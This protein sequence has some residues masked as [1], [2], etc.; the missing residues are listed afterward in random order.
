MT[1]PVLETD[2]GDLITESPAICHYLAATSQP[3]LNGASAIHA[4]QVNQWV[5]FLR[6]KTLP[7][8]KT[9][10]GAV[11]GTIDITP[12]EHAFITNELKE[13]LKTLNNALKSK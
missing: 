10:A 12:E 13:N 3:A 4:A 2:D 11:Y 1:Y 8:A 9:L 6:A 5:M 7:M